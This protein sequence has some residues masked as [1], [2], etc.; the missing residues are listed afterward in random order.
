ME[1][2]SRIESF[3][4]SLKTSFHAGRNSNENAAQ[5]PI[6]VEITFK[7]PPAERINLTDKQI[8]DNYFKPFLAE[9]Y[10][11]FFPINPIPPPHLITHTSV[12]SLILQVSV[13]QSSISNTS[14]V[15]F[16]SNSDVNLF[17]ILWYLSYLRYPYVILH[18]YIAW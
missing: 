15:S 10:P 3:L 18:M 2:S 14:G 6:P 16:F 9:K 4:P 12:V 11:D 5:P 8:L 17:Y 7:I 1:I 13:S